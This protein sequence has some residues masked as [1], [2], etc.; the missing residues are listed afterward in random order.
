MFNSDNVSDQKKTA[1]MSTTFL[2]LD[3]RRPLLMA[4]IMISSY[5]IKQEASTKNEDAP[6]AF[7][8]G[9]NAEIMKHILFFFIIAWKTISQ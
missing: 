9:S 1:S 2:C 3:K 5:L 7:N 6:R 4:G 8:L